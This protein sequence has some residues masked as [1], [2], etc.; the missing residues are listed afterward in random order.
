MKNVLTY[1]NPILNQKCEEVKLP[2]S[3]EDAEL[4][5]E[6]YA[7]VKDPANHAVGLAAPQVGVLK[8]MFVVFNK[9]ADGTVLNLKMVNPRIIKNT[10]EVYNV[11]GGEGCLSEPD[12]QVI[13][14]RCKVITLIGYEAISG[15]TIALK[16]KGYE[17]AVIQHELDHLNGKLLHDYQKEN[18]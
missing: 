4:L 16:F 10:T 15:K 18:K 8:R 11:P 17:A 2:L 6:M 12:T 9:H 3:K 7:F 13:V 5:K 14:N 1:P